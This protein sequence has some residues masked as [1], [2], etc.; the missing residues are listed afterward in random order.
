M[1]FKIMIDLDFR[2][3]IGLQRKLLLHG[4]SLTDEKILADFISY[5]CSLLFYNLEWHGR[6]RVIDLKT[7]WN[8]FAK[9]RNIKGQYDVTK[10]P[11][12]E[13]SIRHSQM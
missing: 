13:Q 7:L 5:C 10:S 6:S 2:A 3:K 4:V 11:N 1:P 8:D 9:D 12:V